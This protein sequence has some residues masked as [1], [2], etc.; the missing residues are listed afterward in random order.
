ME[1]QIC[2]FTYPA[3]FT[4]AGVKID[5]EK[6]AIARDL[7]G[8]EHC[9]VYRNRDLND[10]FICYCEIH[11]LNIPEDAES[12]LELYTSL[13]GYLEEDGFEI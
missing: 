9:A 8:T 1:G 4:Y 12:A 7:L 11:N 5:D 10:M 13:L 6:I 3:G 2:F